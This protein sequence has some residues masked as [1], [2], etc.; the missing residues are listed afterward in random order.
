MIFHW[1]MDEIHIYEKGITKT[2]RRKVRVDRAEAM[3]R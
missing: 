2:R 1:L 3:N